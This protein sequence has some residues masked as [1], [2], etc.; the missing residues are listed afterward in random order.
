LYG[1]YFAQFKPV[2]YTIN[3]YLASILG[4]DTDDLNTA[5]TYQKLRIASAEEVKSAFALQNVSSNAS[6]IAQTV[7][8]TAMEVISDVKQH[9]SNIHP[10]ADSVERNAKITQ[11]DTTLGKF[12]HKIETE[13]VN[14]VV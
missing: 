8:P 12:L 1:V 5:H 13:N 6:E 10:N 11:F 3:A 2:C 14:S 7:T 4:H 9:S